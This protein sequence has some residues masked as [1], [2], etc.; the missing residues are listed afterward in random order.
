MKNLN[1]QTAPRQSQTNSAQIVHKFVSQ[2]FDLPSFKELLTQIFPRIHFTQERK[3]ILQG[4]RLKSYTTLCEPLKLSVLRLS[5]G[6]F[7]CENIRAKISIHT[8]LKEL[9]KKIKSQCDFSRILRTK[10]E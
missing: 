7:E 6:V 3:E 9:L 1:T 10:A 8:E 5:V 2:S 4:A